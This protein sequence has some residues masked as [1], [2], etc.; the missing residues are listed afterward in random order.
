MSLPTWQP[1]QMPTAQV[2]PVP[3]SAAPTPVPATPKRPAK[4]D[5]TT[6]ALLL[7]ASLIAV[8]GV[9]FALGHV[10]ASGS[11]SGI[12]ARPSG[13]DG[14]AFASL[15]P[16]QTFNPG[17]FGGAR[18]GTASISGTVVSFDGTTLVVQEANGSSVSVDIAGTT[19]YHGETSATSSQITPGTNVIVDIA[20]SASASLIPAPGSSTARTLTARDVLIT[21]P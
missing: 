13:F 9:G 21:T 14:R 3:A 7:M 11:T 12:A 6:V 17:D 20:A 2:D 18:I 4:G 16:G 1:D 15:A 19:T 8:G 10:T 5:R